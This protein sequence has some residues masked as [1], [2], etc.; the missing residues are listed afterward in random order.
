MAS[1][2]PHLELLLVITRKESDVM[3]LGI[4]LGPRPL[5][6]PSREAPCRCYIWL[7]SR[8]VPGPNPSFLA[9]LR[10]QVKS[11]FRAVE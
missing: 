11:P 8:E 2:G 9:G 6:P 5:P 10:P 3:Q 7:L 4:V 1:P